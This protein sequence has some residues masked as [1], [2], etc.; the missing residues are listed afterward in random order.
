[1]SLSITP[2]H[3]TV[4]IDRPQNLHRAPRPLRHAIVIGA[5]MGGLL[6][7]N[8]LANHAVAV[9]VFERDALPTGF[10]PRK[11][12]PQ[13]QHVHALLARGLQAIEQAVP[14][15]TAALEAHGATTG[16]PGQNVS[17]FQG[18]TRHLRTMVGTTAVVGTRPLLEGVLRQHVSALPNVTI[19][20]RAAVRNFCW[21]A[22][23]T[24]VTGVRLAER[25]DDS[26]TLCHE[27][28]DFVVD[29]S[30]RGSQAT[31]WLADAGFPI[32]PDSTIDS[33]VRY[34]SRTFARNPNDPSAPVALVCVAGPESPRGGIALA[35]EGNR[36]L[37]TLVGRHHDNPPL[38]LVGFRAFA[39]TLPLP[40]IHAIVESTSPLDDGCRYHTPV[41][42]R[43]HIEQ[44]LRV[45]EGFLL[46]ADSICNFPPVYGQGMSVAALEAQ[47][48]DECLAQGTTNLFQRFASGITPVV[49]NAWELSCT[50]ELPLVLPTA[51]LPRK[52]W[53]VS[54][55]LHQLHQAAATDRIV[56]TAFT[57]VVHLNA[58]A[59]SLLKPRIASR[60]LVE[61]LRHRRVQATG[62]Q[63]EPT[64]GPA[65]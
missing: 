14:G 62:Q 41:S 18:G 27:P 38:D 3:G 22:E 31:I 64:L 48:L 45:P 54:Q 57:N 55:Y 26:F 34:T 19:R 59:T 63:L 44:V 42:T 35:I 37:V 47:V 23:R 46:F 49:D 30:G 9:T 58:S 16:D 25:G 65:R 6:A 39:R 51:E 33:G 21:N 20:D 53:F 12:V 10:E 2:P 7:A 61:R 36:W 8:A 50:G 56:A 13:G 15:Y 11:G 28:A 4:A 29:A 1:M 5:G 43:R 40:D 60:V 52:V 17:W 24:R 32:V